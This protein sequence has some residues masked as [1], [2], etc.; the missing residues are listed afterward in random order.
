MPVTSFIIFRTTSASWRRR[1]FS[2]D[3]IRARADIFD[4]F[5]LGSAMGASVCRAA[6]SGLQIG[7]HLG[8]AA[9]A[10]LVGLGARHREHVPVLVAVRERLEPLARRGVLAQRRREVL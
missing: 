5:V 2:T 9:L 3:A 10:R 6:R 8:D 7:E 4:G 1:S